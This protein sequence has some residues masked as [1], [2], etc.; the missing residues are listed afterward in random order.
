[1]PLCLLLALAQLAR[2]V[3][4]STV[5]QRGARQSRFEGLL[6]SIAFGFYVCLSI[7]FFT[8]LPRFMTQLNIAATM[9]GFVALFVV[10]GNFAAAFIL[11]GRGRVFAPLLSLAA[12]LTAALSCL[13]MHSADANPTAAMGTFAIAGGMTASGIFATVPLLSKSD[14]ERTK[15]IGWIAHGGG[16]ATLLAPPLAGWLLGY[17]GWPAMMY[18]LCTISLLG[19]FACLLLFKASRQTEDHLVRS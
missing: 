14:V 6:L 5:Q 2:P 15:H 7:S 11:T 9:A 17:G 19:A 4:H 12:L 1:V 13:F 10:V 18:S 8:F 16:A 3:E